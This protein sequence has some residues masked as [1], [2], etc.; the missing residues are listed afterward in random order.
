MIE[1][2]E[3]KL[4]ITGGSRGI[5]SKLAAHFAASS[6]V[7][8]ISQNSNSDSE[9][10]GS[11]IATYQADV[12]DE[13]RINQIFEA[14]GPFNGLINCAG[15]LG[16]VG[17]IEQSDMAH[18]SR[19]LSV[20]VLGTAIV[21][22][23]SLPYLM[24]YFKESGKKSKII[25]IAG[26]GAAYPRKHH[27]AYAAS[28]AAVVRFTET[29]SLEI[30]KSIDI[31]S[32]APGA[33]KTDMWKE[34]TYD[35]EPEKWADV[36]RLIKTVEYLLGNSSDGISGKFIHIND[37]WESFSSDISNTDYLSLRRIE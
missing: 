24:S 5:G 36:S 28:K 2:S 32:L 30:G 37:N 29:L 33:H 4:V 8:V 12:C 27:T 9:N 13:T 1:L 25:N 22:K 31:N 23:L 20:N 17:K 11:S 21:T 14:I 6:R 35:K 3:N 26:G 16:P 18:W 19:T 15:I 10:N 7:Y 34:E